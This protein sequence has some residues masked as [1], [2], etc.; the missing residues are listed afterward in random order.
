MNKK[1]CQRL[2]DV[3]AKFSRW[4]PPACATGLLCLP[5]KTGAAT[6]SNQAVTP[7]PLRAAATTKIELPAVT[8]A[9]LILHVAPGGDDRGA[10]TADKP[11]ASLERARDE[12]RAIRQKGALPRGG[13]SVLVHGGEYVA[14]KTLHLTPEDSGNEGEPVRYGA[15]PGEK[16]SF[17]GG[18][19]LSG[20]K[21]LTDTNLY[22]LLPRNSIGKVWYVEMKSAGLTNPM[23]LKLGGFSSGNGFTT[24]PAHEL[25]FNGAALQL[26][27][28]PKEGFLHIAGVVVK[29]GTKG[30]DREGSKTGIFTYQGDLPRKWVAEPDLLLYGYWFWDW[31]DAYERVAGIDPDKRVITLAKPWN[32]YGFSIGA[33][34]Y[35][36]NALSELDQPGEWYMDRLH[37]RILIYPPSDPNAATVEVSTFAAAMVELENASNLRFEGLTWELGSADAIHLQG[38]SNCL[39]AGCTIRHFAGNAIEVQG[40]LNHGVLSCDIYSMGRGGISFSG[41]N[42]KTLSPG[43]HFVEN[44]DIH[45]LSRIDHTYTPAII[46]DGV[47][48]RVRHNRL[49]GIPSSAIRLGGNNHTIEYNE[50]YNVV[51]ESDDQGGIDMW[52]NPTY[53]GNVIRFNYWHHI[54]NWQGRG[55][56]PKCG[57]CAIRL[58]DAICGTLIQG[59]ILER[60]SAGKLGFGGVQIHGGKD[61]VVENNLFVDCMAMLSCSPWDEK[62]WQEFVKSALDDRGIDRELYLQ[63]YPELAGLMENANLNH[64]RN[65]RTIR[66]EELYRRAPKNLDARNNIKLPDGKLTLLPGNPLFSQPGFEKIPVEEMGAYADTWRQL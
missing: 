42:R 46:V 21:R 22:P 35:A 54:G 56:Q 4:L 58:D 27:H 49:H 65:N 3:S 29:D 44:C 19:R 6:A 9:G 28:G 61:N 2:H 16:V 34:F 20:W 10:G 60:C 5:L 8:A 13:V 17:R 25:F 7:L 64:V 45:D 40:G 47:G 24:H 50:I 63:K 32:N 66:C 37:G 26:A 57:Q 36:F 30:Y 15:V 18:L 53:R 43:G 33:P 14:S 62:R 23:P 1:I 48:N 59:N 41:G 52:G 11:F 12:I 38:G 51:T 39:F 55:G 31:A